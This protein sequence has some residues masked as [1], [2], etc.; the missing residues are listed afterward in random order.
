VIVLTSC[1]VGAVT[2][3]CKVTTKVTSEVEASA[4]VLTVVVVV[5]V[6]A[7]VV[8]VVWVVSKVVV[9]SSVMVFST[10]TTSL[11]RVSPMPTKPLG[12][13]PGR[14]LRLTA[15]GCS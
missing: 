14:K 4:V 2:V 9:M 15:E 8:V 11:S 10:P 7:E 1:S 6:V 5:S 3:V 13:M 12:S